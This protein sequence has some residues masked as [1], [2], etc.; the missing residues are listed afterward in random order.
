MIGQTISQY[1]IIEKLGEGGMGVVYKAQDTKLDR[2]VALKF[3]PPHLAASEQD[4]A[5][6]NQEAKSAAALNHPNVCSIIDIQEQNEQIFIVM[7]FVDGHTLQ[8]KKSSLTLKQAIDYGI[9]IA[10]GLAAAHEKGIVHRDIKPEN[11]MIRKDGIVQV[12][13]FGL[14]KL[15][16]VSRLT[17][18]GSTVGTLGYMSPEQVQG[19][20]TDHRSDIFSFGVLLYEMIT[21]KSPFNGAHESAIL[22]E[23]VNV[24]VPPPSS[25]KPEIDAELDRIV[26]ECMEKDPNERMQSVKQVAIDLN[27]FKRTSSRMRASRTFPTGS[28]SKASMSSLKQ[29]NVMTASGNSLFNINR[30]FLAAAVIGIVSTIIF[31]ILYYN[32][33]TVKRMSIRTVITPPEKA[34]FQF[35][36]NNSGPPVISPEGTKI[37]F[38]ANDSMEI[39]RLYVRSLDAFDAQPL[40][41]T[42]GARYPFWSWDGQFVGF[43]APSGKLKK[44]DVSG[45]SPVTICTTADNRGS[46]WSKDGLIVFSA[47]AQGPLFS[48]PASG[49]TPKVITT[50]DSARRESTHRW[51][52]FL[53]DGKHFLYYARTVTTGTQGEGDAICVAS[54]DGK[55]N[56][57]I[58]NASSNAVY[59]SGYLIFV[60]GNGL[61]A[62]RFNTSTLELEGESTEIVQGITYDQSISR[63]LFS[64]SENG[65]M[66]YQTGK[67]QIGSN[68]II[69]DRAGKTKGS[70]GRTAEY[71]LFRNSPDG[72]RIALGEYDQKS[73]NNDIW[74]YETRRDLKTRFTFDPAGDFNPVWSPDGNRVVF[75][76][77]RK[78]KSD[79][80][81]KSSSGASNEEIL[82]ESSSGKVAT[83]WSPNGKDI[84]YTDR[85]DIW[86]LLMDSEGPGNSRKTIPFLQ[87]EFNEG[88][89]HFSP[90]GHWVVYS[91]NESG[92]SEIYLRQFPGPGGKWQV[93][94]AGGFFPT[95]R[96]DGREIYY[97]SIEGKMMASDIAIKGTSVEISSAH[98]L[99]EMRGLNYDV[100]ADGK[101]FILNMP[102]ET[103]LTSPL[104][105]VVNWDLDLKKNK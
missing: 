76:S 42:E 82:L 56:K 75:S 51:P 95:W 17:K 24:D 50:L 41:G 97:V 85:N 43:I 2:F 59:A 96:P 57:I 87:T 49:G 58:V 78:G 32:G 47:G 22:Y 74:L 40:P 94:T 84:L 89:A 16:G 48:V 62:Q 92:Q 55:F 46:T 60:R 104:A 26:L 79:L 6:F 54:I 88:D 20:E 99:F 73:R 103:Q 35:Y 13:D 69:V 21:G 68:L 30:I 67:V 9:Q 83:D 64:V 71:L 33:S 10:E 38:A 93:S 12:M 34:L 81:I 1:K 7:E 65:L 15:V 5:R 39:R 4:K 3:L 52:F 91:S 8:E 45:G 77:N 66:L 63:G 14:A 18:A 86:R 61:V 100:M 29:S 31:G 101:S 36:G 98:A 37:V 19:Q 23:I 70:I 53:P 72:Q 90:D 105:L 11:I 25:V 80:F 28:I 44:I 27:R 102:V